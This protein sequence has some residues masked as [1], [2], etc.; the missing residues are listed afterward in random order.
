VTSF[1][2]C[3]DLAT[4]GLYDVGEVKFE[5]FRAERG[6]NLVG[7]WCLRSWVWRGEE[8]DVGVERKW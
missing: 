2:F 3:P 6:K 8:G 4:V 5:D 1:E 7:F